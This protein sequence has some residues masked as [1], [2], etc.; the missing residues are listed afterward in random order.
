[1]PVIAI[2][3][4]RAQHWD[5]LLF[6]RE[7]KNKDPEIEANEFTQKKAVSKAYVKEESLWKPGEQESTV[8]Q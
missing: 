4:T 2:P 5:P 7:V 3:T 1:M 6:K 8:E